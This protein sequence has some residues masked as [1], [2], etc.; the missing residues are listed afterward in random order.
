MFVYYLALLLLFPVA[1]VV[2]TGHVFMERGIEQSRFI[3]H[4]R[5]T[6]DET[7]ELI[8]EV[9]QLNMLALE[10]LV[11]EI[12]S[13]KSKKY[14]QWL[15][16]KEVLEMTR[17]DKGADSVRVW[18]ESEEGVKVTRKS[19]NLNFITATATIE[20]W[21]TILACTFYQWKDQDKDNDSTSNGKTGN[22]NINTVSKNTVEPP[23]HRALEYSLPENMVPHI[24]AVFNTVQVPVHIHG[25][26]QPLVSPVG[27][28]QPKDVKGK[29]KEE[30]EGEE[31][32]KEEELKGKGKVTVTKAVSKP[33]GKGSKVKA[34]SFQYRRLQSKAQSTTPSL[35][36]KIYKVGSNIGNASLSQSI[37]STQ[38]E[39]YSTTDLNLFQRTYGVKQQAAI[40]RNGYSTAYC[41]PTGVNPSC[42]EGNLDMQYINAMAQ[43]TKTIYWY[44]A[45]TYQV[46]PFTAWAMQMSEEND[47]PDVSSASWGSTE[48]LV[49]HSSKS[50]FNTQAIKLAA[51]GVTLLVATGDDG[52]PNNKNGLCLCGAYAPNFP[53]SSPWVTAVGATQGPESGDDEVACQSQIGGVITSGGGFSNTYPIPDWQKAAVSSYFDHAYTA[54]KLPVS[55]YALTGRGYPDLSLTGAAYEVIVGS[56]ILYMYGT[57]ASAPVLAGM[58]SLINAERFIM[59]RPKIGFINP[60]LYEVGINA[61]LSAAFNDITSGHNRCCRATNPSDATCCTTGFHALTGWDPVTGWGS[62]NFPLFAAMFEVAST[63]TPSSDSDDTSIEGPFNLEISEDLLMT[64]LAILIGMTIVSI[65]Y[66]VLCSLCGALC[67]MRRWLCC[68]GAD[69]EGKGSRK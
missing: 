21:E 66:G 40:A 31:E 4:D 43:D 36:N 39:Y 60:T 68:S 11:L 13:P 62:V 8:F 25:R 57:S 24:A 55:G 14:Q 9:K 7:Q 28:Y 16:N 5:S 23:L 22:K 34:G 26:A 12:S 54:N 19:K 30:G 33:K 65:L 46:D 59:G 6:A 48:S 42:Y 45:N 58:I 49:S 63:Y 35:L 56:Q 44:V 38:E 64:L 27:R 1:A 10:K 41:D 50:A 67:C 47:P 69:D 17:N 15:D 32:E 52:A 18:L 29:G 2:S 61:S 51:Q 53:A 3:R 37:F 20:R